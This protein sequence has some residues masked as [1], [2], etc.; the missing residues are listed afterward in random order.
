MLTSNCASRIYS[1]LEQKAFVVSRFEVCRDVC[2]YARNAEQGAHRM[3]D[4]PALY[5]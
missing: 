5:P 2:N 4:E 1:S 3:T